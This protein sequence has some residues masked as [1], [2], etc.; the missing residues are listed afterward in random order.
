MRTPS[1]PAHGVDGLAVTGIDASGAT[2]AVRASTTAD[3][4]LTVTF[5]E[6]PAE[7][8]LLEA[9]PV[10]LTLTGSGSY[11]RTVTHAFTVPACGQTLL[12]R[13]TA[14]TWPPAAGGVRSLTVTATGGPCPA[15]GTPEP[16]GPA[17]GS[18][19]GPAGGS[20]DD[21]PQDVTDDPAGAGGR[22]SG[23]D[24]AL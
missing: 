23:D 21:A 12:R 22:P 10:T 7:D 2:I 24:G 8:R 4:A 6:G 9:P 17:G 5:A 3:V 20:A 11:L 19:D 13:V 16:G 14:A 18:A 15:P 1:V